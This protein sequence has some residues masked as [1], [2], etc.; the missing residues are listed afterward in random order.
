VKAMEIYTRDGIVENAA[1]LGEY[2]LKR[3]RSEI[4]P[5]PYIGDISGLGLMIGI[6]IVA[7]K[8]AHQPFPPEL[9]ILQK[10]QKQALGAGL[11]M[12]AASSRMAPGDRLSFSPPLS[13]KKADIDRMID[14]LI[15]ILSNI[16]PD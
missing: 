7:D 9:N 3:M 15:P 5:L 12:R 2:A 16:N 14:I 11:F 13:I 8:N 6:E 1:S 10:V 4:L